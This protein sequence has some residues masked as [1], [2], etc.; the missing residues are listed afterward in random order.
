MATSEKAINFIQGGLETGKAIPGQ[1]LTNDPQ[2]PYN[3][4]KPSEYSNPNEAMLYIFESLKLFGNTGLP[5]QLIANVYLQDTN[6][7]NGSLEMIPGSHKLTDFELGEDGDILEKYLKDLDTEKCN[8][9]KGS[10]II[11]DKR[12]WHR[13]TSNP[14]M[15]LRHMIGTSYVRVAR[16]QTSVLRHGIHDELSIRIRTDQSKTTLFQVSHHLQSW[17]DAGIPEYPMVP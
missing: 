9:P 5:L 10:V 8:L 15:S 16:F 2:Q 1:S 6:E 7:E 17:T 12:T 4:E 11:R 14:N 13:G 3:W